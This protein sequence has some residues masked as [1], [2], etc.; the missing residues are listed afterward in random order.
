MRLVSNFTSKNVRLGIFLLA[1]LKFSQQTNSDFSGYIAI[2]V[3]VEGAD[4]LIV[5]NTTYN[6][7]KLY[8]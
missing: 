7:I 2:E 1:P 8:L 6:H 3:Q 4:D 5:G